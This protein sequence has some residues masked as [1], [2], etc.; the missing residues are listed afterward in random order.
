MKSY[1]VLNKQKCPKN[2]QRFIKHALKC[3]V[4]KIMS[5]KQNETRKVK[6]TSMSLLNQHNFML[7]VEHTPNVHKVSHTWGVIQRKQ[8]KFLPLS[9][10]SLRIV[11]ILEL[12]FWKTG[13]DDTRL[14]LSTTPIFFV[15]VLLDLYDSKVRVDFNNFLLIQ[16]NSVFT[17]V[18]L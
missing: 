13:Q 5:A 2:F 18:L 4:P 9:D 17:A 8:S 3:M 1:C 10:C 16:N 15:W 7:V 12:D 6:I 14:E 11:K